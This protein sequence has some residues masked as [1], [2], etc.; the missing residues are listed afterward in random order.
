MNDKEHKAIER[1]KTAS[2]MSL[3]HY[4][5]PLV[6]T[7]SGGKDSDVML[8]LFIRSGV[9]FEVHHSHTTADAS[10]TIYHIREVFRQLEL[11]GIK[12]DIDYHIQPDGSRI[13][14]WNLIPKK[15]M[16]PTRFVRYCCSMLKESGHSNRMIATGIRWDESNQRKKRESFEVIGHTKKEGIFVSDEK[17]LLT[18]NDE[19]RRLF[20]KCQLKAATVVNPIIDWTDNEIW[21]F[22]QHECL[23][24][25]PL[26][27]MG[28]ARVGCIGCPMAG[29]NRWKEFALF[30]QYKNMYIHAFDRMLEVRKE[31]GLEYRN[32][33]NKTWKNGK[34]VFQ[35]WMQ[36][37]DMT[38]QY[39]MEIE[40]ADLTGGLK[41][42]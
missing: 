26:Y 9:P 42:K 8:E 6:C 14:M 34:D 5:K 18:D 31:K 33:S 19:R 4:E 12:C 21:D 24:H 40:N 39:V 17:M 7:Y 29:K 25:N 1:I 11:K 30:P 16:P 28:F 15:L 41:E 13:T 20:E 38:G 32:E 2:E 35:W 37:K 36:D 27:Q 23:Y 3:F 22:Y 10:P